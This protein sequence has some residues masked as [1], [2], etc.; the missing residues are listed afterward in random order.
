[1]LRCSLNSMVGKMAAV[2]D[3]EIINA[4]PLPVLVH[5]D[6]TIVF[7]NLE[8]CGVLGYD[9]AGAI[10]GQASQQLVHA[11]DWPAVAE[12]LQR[13]RSGQPTP[14]AE[15]RWCGSAGRVI[16]VEVT[17][18]VVDYEGRPAC[19]VTG[20]DITAR[21]DAEQ[22][23]LSSLHEKEAL[24]REI[25]HR[26][27]NNLQIVSSV[28]Y[29]QEELVTDAGARAQLQQSQS[30]VNTIALV[31][32]HLYRSADLAHLDV[33]SYLEALVGSL[34]RTLHGARRGITAAVDVCDVTLDIDA[35]IACGLVVCELVT[36]AFEHG[37]VGRPSGHICA[38]LRRV[39][40][41]AIL[42]VCD[43]GVGIPP[44]FD[45]AVTRTLGFELVSSFAE[46]LNARVSIR[47]HGGTFVELRFPLGG[48]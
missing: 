24:L 2:S 34:A 12:R 23:L 8:A 26:V 48:S 28:L 10:V 35:A 15:I 33:R 42:A 30:R 37:F 9:D 4:L 46:Q 43:D 31:H 44:S 41:M 14:F 18:M 25:H 32:E 36:N 6:D 3:R 47:R 13:A 19:L 39:G 22:R 29:L 20:R 45:P 16:W 38:S 17:C 27:K 1:M 40:Q 7:A 5:Q 11:D 21:R